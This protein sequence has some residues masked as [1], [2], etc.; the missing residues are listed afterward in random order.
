MPFLLVIGASIIVQSIP[1]FLLLVPSVLTKCCK[2]KKRFNGHSH[3]TTISSTT[4]EEH[5]NGSDSTPI[6]KVVK[7]STSKTPKNVNNKK[8]LVEV[9]NQSKKTAK[10]GQ[11]NKNEEKPLKIKQ[12]K[13]QPK[14]KKVKEPTP[15]SVKLTANK[16][17]IQQ[18]IIALNT[19]GS[20]ITPVSSS[21]SSGSKSNKSLKPSLIK[22][23]EQRRE[24]FASIME[25]DEDWEV[26]KDSKPHCL[27]SAASHLGNQQSYP[28]L[29]KPVHHESYRAMQH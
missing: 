16:P 21:S 3:S 29:W 18:R 2:R 12:I 22:L 25:V 14:K 11:A 6:E 17:L 8:G 28:N 19:S 13:I 24:K 27:A 4:T 1:F 10:S 20:R 15:P 23:K 26:S 5:P 7:V 9:K